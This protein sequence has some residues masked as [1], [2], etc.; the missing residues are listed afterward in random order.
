MASTEAKQLQSKKL[1]KLP[2]PEG[3]HVVRYK[4]GKIVVRKKI[5]LA[6]RSN[7][8][9][10]LGIVVGVIESGMYIPLEEYKKEKPNPETPFM[11]SFGSSALLLTFAA[12]FI[13]ILTKCFGLKTAKEIF[14]I[15]CLKVMHPGITESE[16]QQKYYN[17]Y[18]SVVF[19]GVAVSK[20]SI[21]CLYNSIGLDDKARKQYTTELLSSVYYTILYIDGVTIQHN[22]PSNVFSDASYKRKSLNYKVYNLIYVFSPEAESFACSEIFPGRFSD[23]SAYRKFL[24]NNAIRRGIIIGDSAFVPSVVRTLKRGSKKYAE[25]E[26]IGVLRD[27][28]KRI[29]ALNLM[30]YTGVFD[31]PKG[32][33]YFSK[34][35]DEE[36]QVWCYGFK[37]VDIS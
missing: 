31:S 1:Q 22:S 17:S 30:N 21:A 23:T 2:H 26:Y 11:V 10:K 18:L 25:L 8:N 24:I 19:P 14:V 15:A 28:D 36:N 35:W 3:T 33:V 37:N 7:P 20:N 6:E 34:V 9:N 5:P 12:I 29:R 16:I 13:T 4:S 27:N 32:K